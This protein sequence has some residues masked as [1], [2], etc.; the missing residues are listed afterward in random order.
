MQA[1]LQS[2]GPALIPVFANFTGAKSRKLDHS[3]TLG[4]VHA[5]DNARIAERWWMA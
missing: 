3:G 4:N 2:D 1:I 5:L